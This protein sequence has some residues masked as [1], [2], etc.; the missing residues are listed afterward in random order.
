[1]QSEQ[2]R[3]EPCILNKKVT[4][5]IV[6]AWVSETLRACCRVVHVR[7]GRTEARQ[8]GCWEGLWK[9]R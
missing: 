8:E 2:Q 3:E 5:N 7:R 4:P 9:E 6:P 1:V